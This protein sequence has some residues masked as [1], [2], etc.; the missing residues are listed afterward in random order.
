MRCALCY[1]SIV[2]DFSAIVLAGGKSQRMG[3][4]KALLDFGGDPLI[5]HLVRKLERLFDEIIVVAAPGQEL[6]SMPVTVVQD[7]IAHQGPVGGIYYGLRAS[8]STASFVTSC[9]VPFLMPSLVSNLLGRIAE[10][11]I[12]VPYWEGRLQP[13]HAVYRRSVLPLLKRQLEAGQLRPIYLYDK[14]RTCE[15]QEDDIRRVD[16]EGA[17]FVNM[18]TPEDYEAAVARWEAGHGDDNRIPQGHCQVE[19]FGV[20]KLR[21]KTSRL[22]IELAGSATLAEIFSAVA[23]KLPAL[24]GTVIAPTRDSLVSG[25]ACNVN[26]REFV[27]DPE[28]VIQPGDHILLVS[29]DAGG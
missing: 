18:N 25:N 15:V 8:S 28:F 17:S 2:S 9:D 27:T 6:P 7:E 23:E 19:L 24:V 16:P 21:A 11:D 3:R 12:V 10:W 5:L 26:G 1:G 29:S 4:P 20:A 14:V 13:L 22:S